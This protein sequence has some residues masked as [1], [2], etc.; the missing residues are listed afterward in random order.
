L[1]V[2]PDAEFY[3][4]ARAAELAGKAVEMEP[5]NGSYWH[6]L[7]KARYR[8]GEWQAAIDAQEK[9]FELLGSQHAWGMFYLAMAHWQ[10]GDKEQARTWY[11]RALELKTGP[12]GNAELH[13]LEIE[14]AKLLDIE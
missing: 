4:P 10:L 3:D 14:A 12:W 6:T 11:E 9:A 1:V 5:G 2:C 8:L 13:R 7:G